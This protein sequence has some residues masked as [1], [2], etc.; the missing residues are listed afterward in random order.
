MKQK[1][2]YLLHHIMHC[3]V[4][5]LRACASR[6]TQGHGSTEE[7]ITSPLGGLPKQLSKFHQSCLFQQHGDSS[8]H[9]SANIWLVA[10]CLNS[11]FRCGCSSRA[12]LTKRRSFFSAQLRPQ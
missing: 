3:C 7:D 9:N 11:H 12:S 1:E 4:S 5:D 2:Q 10:L 8:F 6:R